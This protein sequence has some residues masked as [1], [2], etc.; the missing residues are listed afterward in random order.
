MNFKPMLAPNKQLKIKDLP[1][2]LMGSYKIDGIRCISK[3]GTLFSRSLKPI[4]NKQL[5][6]RFRFL[7]QYAMILD[8]EFYSKSISFNEL[9]GICRSL[10]RTLPD[11]LKFYCFDLYNLG[12]VMGQVLR[13]NKFKYKECIF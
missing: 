3:D 5:H 9:S 6:E 11:D 2:P 4:V 10:D 12:G 1:L 7:G 13:F 8:G